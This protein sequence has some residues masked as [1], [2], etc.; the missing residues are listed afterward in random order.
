MSIF[1]EILGVIDNAFALMGILDVISICG[2]L[3]SYW[4]G[5]LSGNATI[6]AGVILAFVNI[7]VGAVISDVLQALVDGI[8]TAIGTVI[9]GIAN[10]IE[11]IFSAFR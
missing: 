9:E 7:I 2:I 1:D 10:A 6:L 11:S 4:A 8:V 3:I 5:I